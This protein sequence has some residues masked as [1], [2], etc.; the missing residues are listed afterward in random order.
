MITSKQKEKYN[1]CLKHTNELGSVFTA[2][3]LLVT[4]PSALYNITRFSFNCVP[5]G[6]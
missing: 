1:Q 5:V 3:D 6:S 2:L 4:I